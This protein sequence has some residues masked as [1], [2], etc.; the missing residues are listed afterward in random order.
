M[1]VSFRFVDG[2]AETVENRGMSIAPET[3]AD[4][5]AV[6]EA[7]ARKTPI[8]PEIAKRVREKSEAVR[9]EFPTE[10]SLEL[11]RAAREE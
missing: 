3:S 10:L 2:T 1:S 9:R 6:F 8:D 5:K 7:V 4:V 11:L